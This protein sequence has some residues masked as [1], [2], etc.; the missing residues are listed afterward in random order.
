MKKEQD[1]IKEV[2]RIRDSYAKKFDYDIDAIAKDIKEKEKKSE[3]K[4]VSFAA[5]SNVKKAG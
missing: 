2:R 4:I 5:K 3:R 1:P